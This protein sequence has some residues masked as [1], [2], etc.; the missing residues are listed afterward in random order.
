MGILETP[1]IA[2][3]TTPPANYAGTFLFLSYIAAALYCTLNLSTYLYSRFQSRKNALYPESRRNVY[4]FSTLALIS[5]TTL[6]YNMINVL[7]RSYSE[8]NATGHKQ[9]HS[10]SAQSLWSWMTGSTLFIDFAT[11]LIYAR[12]WAH[13]GLMFALAAHIFIAVEGKKKGL[14]N[15]WLYHVLG[16]ILP[17]SFATNLVMIDSLLQPASPG[18]EVSSSREKEEKA[19]EKGVVAAQTTSRAS[20]QLID[21]FDALFDRVDPYMPRF[22]LGMIIAYY[23]EELRFA[24]PGAHHRPPP[25]LSMRGM[26][27]YPILLLPH[28]K[29]HSH[30]EMV[31]PYALVAAGSALLWWQGSRDVGAEMGLGEHFWAQRPAVKA[32]TVDA[33]VGV[34]SL[35]VWV[36]AMAGEFSREQVARRFFRVEAG[37]D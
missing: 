31:V 20:R 19:E 29:P 25:I 26:L 18:A 8:N 2:S 6:S 21:K 30:R 23:T 17:P 36:L 24:T 9:P 5:F 14:Q 27:A 4:I 11:D 15:L 32:V 16:Q 3:M 13:I 37:Y 1:F 22:L 12:P 34:L 28:S 10:F 35:A 7:F 33:F